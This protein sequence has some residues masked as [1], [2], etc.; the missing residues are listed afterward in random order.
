MR[1]G[2]GSEKM[3]Q[4]KFD[5]SVEFDEGK[6]SGPGGCRSQ[7]ECQ[8]FCQTNP[9]ACEGMGEQERREGLEGQAGQE[10]QEGREGE[11]EEFMQPGG[12]SSQEECMELFGGMTE[13][14]ERMMKPE[15]LENHEQWTND[16]QWQSDQGS[17]MQEIKPEWSGDE[18]NN[19]EPQFEMSPESLFITPST[20]SPSFDQ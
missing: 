5:E 16:E 3:M 9:Q 1:F 19:V 13:E 8:A 10:G 18:F 20:Q 7:E 2:G 12:C 6:F 15:D 4:E 14:F 11:Q 17:L